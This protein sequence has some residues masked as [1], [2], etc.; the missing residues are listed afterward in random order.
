[1]RQKKKSIDLGRAVKAYELMMMMKEK[2]I[3]NLIVV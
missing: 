3:V 2:T 1:M